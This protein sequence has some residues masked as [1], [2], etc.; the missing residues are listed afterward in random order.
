MNRK[1]LTGVFLCWLIL[2]SVSLSESAI[3]KFNSRLRFK[4]QY[5]ETDA[6]AEDDEDPS[7][8]AETEAPDDSRPNSQSELRVVVQPDVIQVQRG[9][10]VELRCVVYGADSSTSVFWVQE[11]PERRHAQIDHESEN[12][13]EITASQVTLRARITLD[14][15]TKIGTYSCMAQ[16]SSG[17]TASATLTM[18]EG[19]ANGGHSSYITHPGTMSPSS[20]G[21]LRIIVPNIAEGDS[22]QIQCEGA[23]Q[24]D[25]SRIQW[26]FNNRII[27]DDQPFYP[28]GR[29]LHINPISQSNLGNYRCSIPN[30]EYADATSDLTFIGSGSTTIIPAYYT[31]PPVVGCKYDEATCNNGNCIPRSYVCD[32]KN[33]C[34]DN[35]DE[36]CNHGDACQ[37]NEIR[38]I[39]RTRGRKCV[40]KFWTCDGDRDCDDGSDEA[41]QYCDVL[42]RHRYC[43]QN[44]YQ[45]ASMNGS[46]GNPICIPRSFQ[47]DS[48][49]DCPDRS[50]EIGCAKP[51]ILTPPQRQVEI[52][53]GDT[54]TLQ[55]TVRGTPAPYI[56][57]R[58][59]WGHICRD[60]AEY[61]RCTMIQTADPNDSSVITGILTIRNVNVNDGGAYSCEAL[62]NQGFT[63]AVPDAIVSVIVA[64]GQSSAITCGAPP[65][66]PSTTRPPPPPPPP[67]R[68][69]PPP[70]PY[71][72]FCNGHSDRCDENGRC[73]DC[74]HNTIGYH[75]ELC[76]PGYQGN[77]AGGT[78]CDCQVIV[79]SSIHRCDPAGTQIERGGRCICKYNVEGERCDRCKRSHF[80]LS[81]DAPQGCFSCFCSGVSADCRSI[82][83]LRK[84]IALDIYNWNAVPKDFESNS[85]QVNDG[86]QKLNGG[87][88]LAINQDSLGRSSKEVLYWKAPSESLGNFVT[89]YDGNIEVH[90]TNDGNDR[91]EP[92][93]DEAI[94]LRGN[95]IDLVHKLP[96]TQ[97]FK[98]NT[99]DVYSV[100]CNER[101]FTRRDGGSVTREIVLMAL[102][103]LDLLLIKINPIGGH[104]NAVLHGVTLSVASREGRAENAPSVETCHCPSNYTG[105]SCEKC[106][107]GYGRVHPIV[108]FYLGH[109]LSCQSLC[110]GRAYQCDQDTGKCFN[111]QGNSEGDH[112]ERC[113]SGYMLDERTNQCVLKDG[114]SIDTSSPSSIRATYLI[115]QKPYNVQG[116]KPFHIT[117]NGGQ[118]E[119]RVRLQIIN[120]QPRTVVWR[121]SDGSALP[122]AV[123]QIDN[124][125]IFRNPSG[126]Q[127]GS[128]VGTVTL[129][130]GTTE[131][132]VIHLDY[133]PGAAIKLTIRPKVIQL[134]EG[135][136]LTVQ[137][138]V[139]SHDSV[140][141]V[142]NRVTAD[143][144]EPMPSY[145]EVGQ[146]HLI[147]QK[148]T[149]D[150]AGT[151]RVVARNAYSE[152]T[153]EIQIKV[154]PR[155]RIRVQGPPQIR[156]AQDLYSISL[157]E[158][159]DIIPTI[160]RGRGATAVWTKVGSSALPNG[161]SSR[162]NGVL[163]IEG[164]SSDVA[165]QYSLDVTTD[166]GRTSSAI[167]V[168]WRES[169][170][171]QNNH[172]NDVHDNGHVGVRFQARDEQN[173]HLGQDINLQCAV[174]GN[175]ER[176]YEYAY[177]KD[178]QA[179]ADN[180]EVHPDGLLLIR[181]AQSS[182]AGRYRCQVTFPHAPSIQTQESSYDLRITGSSNG[183]EEWNGHG[184]E[185]DREIHQRAEAVEVFVEPAEVTLGR[186]ETARITCHVKNAQQYKVTWHRYAHDTSLPAYA[187]QEGNTIVL[188]PNE[189]SEAEQLYFQC[190]VDV[191]GHSNPFHAYSP[192]TIRSDDESRK[193]KKKRYI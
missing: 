50:D 172:G 145:F 92:S 154:A 36:T 68:P 181:N 114:S 152:D 185:N 174:Y 146:N 100:A 40:Q 169:S 189:N 63:F 14:D 171:Q 148:A 166:Q 160:A 47:C 140:S 188:E 182:D 151:Y 88:D 51:T 56:N 41:Q 110:R 115:D 109:C 23:A 164:H 73:L 1:L 83:W 10:T 15:A 158:A 157:G 168:Q 98:A 80:Y 119:Q 170:N 32:G 193:K 111:C 99:R 183:G 135:Q 104:R 43:K 71:V 178:G 3:G 31:R 162:D 62:N 134:K 176:P 191:P 192:V 175:V 124:D 149:L 105:T 25:E 7:E 84:P 90:F 147:L 165:G 52:K 131:S 16:D 27:H 159:I 19:G 138:V 101:T 81:L 21:H 77:A 65:P 55:C 34:G 11:E 46:N 61:N 136:R 143:G 30:S 137:Y 128:Y 116:S 144:I 72:C 121:R 186:G 9:Q 53:L 142:W 91:E 57:W 64:P 97:R 59:N 118:P 107:E 150:A 141:V 8:T 179:L 180:V 132:I 130:D 33:D 117:L 66:P 42:P 20:K 153:Q 74:R 69:A 108:G 28:R 177:T 156:F 79:P 126:D 17:H 96:Q 122:A 35:S 161:V 49:N 87:H 44:E 133:H 113:R 13:R 54:L 106:A 82:D 38:C 173:H 95:N 85:Y 37:P 112:C 75:C 93:D 129:S 184:E 89:L 4:R 60:C 6:N 26:Y 102:A 2:A 39:D 76:A 48:Y 5:D 103:D 45:C 78:S 120:A 67:T 155:R 94:W 139:S 123:V 86:I 29:T 127:A 187:R 58:L 163:H 24:E 125:L 22:V 18:R 167:Y 70:I 12:D 190:Q